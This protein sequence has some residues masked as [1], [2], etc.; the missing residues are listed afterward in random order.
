M[1]AS[2]KKL[3]RLLNGQWIEYAPHTTLVINPF[4]LVRDIKEDMGFLLPIL[5]EMA[6]PNEGLTDFAQSVLQ[7]HVIHCLA[8]A[9]PLR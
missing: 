1:G 2:Y 5:T 9:M 8:K 7:T 3:C 6:S 4:E